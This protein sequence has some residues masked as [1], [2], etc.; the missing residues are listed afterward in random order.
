MIKPVAKRLL[1]LMLAAI[2][3]VGATGC[4]SS[5]V[6]ASIVEEDGWFTTWG[7]AMLTA[8][9]DETPT[10]PSLKQNTCRQQVRVSI[11]GDKIRITLSNEYGDIPLN[12]ES[13]HIAHLVDSSSSTIDTSTDTVIT[14][15]GGSESV[16]LSG[17]EKIVS[18]EVDFSFD[19]LDCLAITIKFGNYVGGTI[20]CHTAARCS[21]WIVEGDHVSDETLTG[22]SVMTST[23]YIESV[24]TWAEAGTK[25]VVCIGDSITDGASSTDNGYCRYPDTL[26]ELLA[27]DDSV[28]NVAVVNKGIGGNAVFGG[29]G[30]ALVDRFQRDVIDVLADTTGERY[31]IL[32]I[33][34]NDIGYE[35]EDLSESIIDAYEELIELCHENDILIYAGTLTPIEGSTYY[36]ELHDETRVA[37]NEYIRSSKSKFDGYIDFDLALQDPDN[38]SKLLDDYVSVWNDYLH[39]NDAGYAEMGETA[40]EFLKEIL[41]A[42]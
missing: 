38:T 25:T 14:F 3:L 34:I 39:P 13:V 15:N 9:A 35:S 19:A 37:L 30:D 40:Y 5:T 26:M 16:D 31:C 17:G 2:L 36:S 11:G 27:A 23:Y 32:L 21:T 8:S 41:A 42:E 24:E 10:S 6:G 22:A 28:G 18:D 4:E 1:S 12:I 20:T 7:T 29:L 33:G